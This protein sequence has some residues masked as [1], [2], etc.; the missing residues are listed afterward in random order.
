MY[1]WCIALWHYQ[2]SEVM[3]EIDAVA[4]QKESAYMKY[5]LNVRKWG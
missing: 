5:F 4:I 3:K 1:G 2:I